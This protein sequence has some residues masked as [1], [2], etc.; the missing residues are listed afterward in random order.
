MGQ[1]A[2]KAATSRLSRAGAA[3]GATATNRAS[4]PAN[5]VA[6]SSGSA[7]EGMSSK[8]VPWTHPS[9]TAGF[10][11]G[12]SGQEDV[13]DTQQREFLQKRAGGAS[14][15]TELPDDLVQ[16]L[17]SAGPLQKREVVKKPKQGGVKSQPSESSSPP[18]PAAE[19]AAP[20]AATP[21]RRRREVMPLAAN[22]EGFGTERTT[23]FSYDNDDAAPALST[24]AADGDASRR[25]AADEEEGM[26]DVLDLY[27]LL[28][29]GSNSHEF[30]Q[31]QDT[32]VRQRIVDAQRYLEVP[33]VV[34]ESEADGFV[35]VH[36]H[37]LETLSVQPVPKTVVKLVLEDLVDG[38][39]RNGQSA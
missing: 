24:A 18:P 28:V 38:Q 36:R 14:M 30:S 34:K 3:S 12:E 11:R 35:G 33:V 37:T 17:K 13:R 25:A 10:Q 20:A 21:K 1:Q 2:F 16:F 15:P 39:S 23:N 31:I 4:A 29:S 32:D 27:R 5:A 6:G 22:V 26:Y 8:Q 9:N 19:A 7:A